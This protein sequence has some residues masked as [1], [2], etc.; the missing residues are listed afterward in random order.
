MR[1]FSFVPH[2]VQLTFNLEMLL[3]VNFRFYYIAFRA[4]NVY[5]L[6]IQTHF[7]LTF[8]RQ[9]VLDRSG[10]SRYYRSIEPSCGSSGLQ[11]YSDCDRHHCFSHFGLAERQYSSSC[12]RPRGKQLSRNA[13]LILRACSV[14]RIHVRVPFQLVAPSVT[15]ICLVNSLG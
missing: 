15:N 14:L 11:W 4:V 7:I 12:R 8:S 1:S 3:V 6:R 2:F 9:N 5:H 13:Q 10:G